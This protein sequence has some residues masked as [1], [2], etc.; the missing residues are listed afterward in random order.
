MLLYPI[1]VDNEDVSHHGNDKRMQKKG[2]K[3]KVAQIVE[4]NTIPWTKYRRKG[5]DEVGAAYEGY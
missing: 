2:V 1:F 3:I 5:M 4:N